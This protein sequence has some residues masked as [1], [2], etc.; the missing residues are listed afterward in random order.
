MEQQFVV[1]GPMA[2][3]VLVVVVVAGIYFDLHSW[4][5]ADLKAAY[6]G[7]VVSEGTDYHIIGHPSK[8]RYI[9]IQDSTGKRTKRY[10]DENGYMSV[11]V[12]TYVVKRA[13]W[14]EIP[15]VPGSPL[16]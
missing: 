6:A 7:T 10:V 5:D 3:V 1:K 4:G 9:V 11:K 2:I 14:G 12:G 15:R 13:G 16:P 8:N